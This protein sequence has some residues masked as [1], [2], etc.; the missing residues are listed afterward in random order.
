MQVDHRVLSTS[1]A[2]MRLI[3]QT[4]IYNQGDFERLLSYV[5]ENYAAAALEAG[6]ADERLRFLRNVHAQVGRLRVKHVVTAEKHHVVVLMETERGEDF[7]VQDL[8]CEEDYPHKVTHFDHY[9][10]DVEF[11]D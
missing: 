8:E 1:Q 9:R 10:V 7:F 5:R 2:G 4:S 11:K 3:A 6:S